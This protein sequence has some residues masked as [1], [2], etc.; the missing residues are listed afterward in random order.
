L[1]RHKHFEELA[2]VAARGELTPSQEEELFLHLASC[3]PCRQ[4]HE[5]F[6]ELH[7]PLRPSL[8][9]A[10]DAIIESRRGKLKSAM[11]Q[12]ISAQETQVPAHLAFSAPF[13]VTAIRWN[14]LHPVWAGLATA[15]AL[16]FAFS[17]GIRYE[18]RVLRAQEH[19][20]DKSVAVESAPSALAETQAQSQP[21]DPRYSQ[22][23]SDFRAEKQRS[24]KLDASL[25]GKDRE[26]AESQSNRLAVQHQ[27][28]SQADELRR[29]QTLLAAKTDELSQMEAA[30]S[31]DGTTLL[32]LQYQV[33]DLTQKLNDQKG[34]LGRERDLL[35]NGR[36]I[37][38][39]IGARNLHIID[40]YDTD[41][42][43]ST[44]KSFARAFYTEGK[45]LVFYAYDL[46]RG[47]ENGKL[48][49]TA[50][51]EKNGS[52]RTVRNLGVLVNDDK[53]EKRWV[54]NFSDP[55]VLAEIDSVFI[56]L[57]R[58]GTDSEEPSGK[59]M[60]TAYLDSQVNHP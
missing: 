30:K 23:L 58:T 34:S 28:D 32:A 22:L 4:V 53:G 5:E 26:L 9:P 15:A 57:E 8:D 20:L 51:G 50:W 47:T 6:E 11:L 60:L 44:R 42:G 36:D 7:E 29:T 48:V 41:S 55:K 56:T 39:I 40:V 1:P 37:R 16:A 14:A 24:A 43:G 45:S 13:S 49:F 10:M 12:A 18:Q 21:Q 25:A 31:E 46:P 27:L 52:K 59:R 35:A 38:D 54:L 33:Q 19:T 3:N 2:A 17:L